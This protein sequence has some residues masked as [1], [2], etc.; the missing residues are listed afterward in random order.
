MWFWRIS[1]R[2]KR[3]EKDVVGR[4][5]IGRWIGWVGVGVLA[6]MPL[7]VGCSRRMPQRIYH[8]P[9]VGPQSL[10]VA[11]FV[12]RSGS[13]SLDMVEVTRR[14]CVELQRVDHMEVMPV[15]QV[16]E[17]M[18][19]QGIE[20]VDSPEQ[21]LALAGELDVDGIIVGAVMEYDPYDPPRVGMIVHLYTHRNRLGEVSQD[22]ADVAGMDPGQIAR[23]GRPFEM[24][25]AEPIRPV[26]SV[27]RIIDADDEA[28]I[29]RLKEYART[30]V[31]DAGPSG[32]RKY[33]GSREYLGFVA[34]EII[35]ELLAK[36]RDRLLDASVDEGQW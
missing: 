19:S 35:G 10:A 32:W 14:F 16:L 11:L 23:Q 5:S 6:L 20:S 2:D 8:S 36:E 31:G 26:Q 30:R 3:T 21:A 25:G 17:E 12:N 9:Y 33:K 28:V 15:Q 22:A 13:E 24:T 1:F 7:L 4:D 29:Q 34:H 18:Y 27:M